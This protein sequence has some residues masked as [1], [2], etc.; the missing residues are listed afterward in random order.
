[1]R[2]TLLPIY[3]RDATT[4]YVSAATTNPNIRMRNMPLIASVTLLAVL[5]MPAG[6]AAQNNSDSPATRS[7]WH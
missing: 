4:R 7:L 1:M 6:L 2:P 3:S 5:A